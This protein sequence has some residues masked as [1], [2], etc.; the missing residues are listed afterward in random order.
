[1]NFNIVVFVIHILTIST[2]SHGMLAN[3]KAVI[4]FPHHSLTQEE[5]NNL[6][7][8]A[9]GRYTILKEPNDCAV[10]GP[11]LPCQLVTLFNTGK[12]VVGH[13]AYTSDLSTLLQAVKLEF[14]ELNLADTVGKI[15]TTEDPT[16]KKKVIPIQGNLFSLQDL[17]EGRSQTEEVKKTK[18]T[19]IDVLGIT[20]RTHIKAD[21]FHPKS[22]NYYATR[23]IFLKYTESTINLFNICPVSQNIYDQNVDLSLSERVLAFE[24][25]RKKRHKNNAYFLQFAHIPISLD[26]YSK[27]PFVKI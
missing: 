6:K 9:E 16:Y 24:Q 8:V 27:F 25:E 19:I 18:D 7:I 5:K 10:V 17:H 12:T 3:S 14:Q 20:D 13:L 26:L 4:P 2:L 1:M 23:Y 22:H 21:I 15:Y 11:L